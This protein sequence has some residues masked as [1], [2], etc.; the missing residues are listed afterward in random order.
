MGTF[1]GLRA[2]DG[3]SIQK[4][5]MDFSAVVHVVQYV[6]CQ[7]NIDLVLVFIAS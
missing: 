3:N 7:Y 6:K 5:V 1:I 2:F 4:L